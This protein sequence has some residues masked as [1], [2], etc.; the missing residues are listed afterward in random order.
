MELS[1]RDDGEGVA[2]GQGDG[3]GGG[4][5]GHAEGDGLGLMDGRRQEDSVGPVVADNVAGFRACVGRE[6]DEREG[7]V[8]VGEEGDELRGLAREGDEEE[9]VVPGDLAEVAVQGL[10]GMQEYGSDGEAVEGCDELLADMPGLADAND[11]QLAAVDVVAAGYGV[12]GAAETV[13]RKAVCG[14]EMGEVLEGGG[15]GGEDVDG[16]REALF[17][18]ETSATEGETGS[19]DG[20]IVKVFGRRD[21]RGGRQGRERR[22]LAQHIHLAVLHRP[23]LRALLDHCDG[24]FAFLV[25]ASQRSTELAAC[26]GAT[27]SARVRV[28][29]S[30]TC[31]T[32]CSVF[33]GDG[34]ECKSNPD[35]AGKGQGCSRLD[36][37]QLAERS[38]GPPISPQMGSPAGKL[39][40]SSTRN[41]GF[42]TWAL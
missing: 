21:G 3:R 1:R 15:L 41:K 31:S 10:G 23:L 24:D 16:A 14:V 20:R 28:I 34:S 19:V 40:G 29:I 38:M 13:A 36:L 4:G 30:Y 25:P 37:Q 32:A 42:Q 9:G 27:A 33:D 17:Y 11:H 6:E 2:D 39:S 12:D 7:L 5:S 18:S 26:L 8:E 22:H 35:D